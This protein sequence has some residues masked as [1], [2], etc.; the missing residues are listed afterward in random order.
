MK[1][2]NINYWKFFNKRCKNLNKHGLKICLI[3]N[4]SMELKG[5]LTDGDVRRAFLKGMKLN[6]KVSAIINKK[7]F[8]L[9]KGDYLKKNIYRIMK[10]KDVK[11]VPIL[12][13]KKIVD[14][15]F[16][17]DYFLKNSKIENNLIILAGGFGKRLY[18]FTKN[19]PKPM[20]IVKGKLSEHIIIN[21]RN[22]GFYNFTI[23]VHY[24]KKNN[25]LF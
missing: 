25:K 3:V 6:N 23:I 9:Q 19:K 24:L 16:F 4:D 20:I 7:F 1:W 2:K 12:E 21:A 10:K 17:D 15:Y 18:P 22:E 14:L 13:K 8:S 11:F 5:T